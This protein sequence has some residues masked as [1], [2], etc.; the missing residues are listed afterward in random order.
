[1]P[2]ELADRF[3]LLRVLQTAER[4]SQAVVLRVR[5]LRSGTPDVPWCSSG[6]T[7][8]TL[9]APRSA[10]PCS[11]PAGSRPRATHLEHLLEAGRA[12]GHPY[13]LYRSHGE[14]HLGDY[15]REHPARWP[16][17]NWSRS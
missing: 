3:S 2:P 16:S 14:T 1:M 15:Q 9:P 8:C 7:A 12:D 5:D 4:P 11:R 10:G 6:T 17:S 13:H